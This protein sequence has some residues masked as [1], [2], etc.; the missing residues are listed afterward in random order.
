M[1][2]QN[3]CTLTP[4]GRKKIIQDTLELCSCEFNTLMVCQHP[5]R[6]KL[7]CSSLNC[8]KSEHEFDPSQVF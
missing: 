1:K 5:N 3:P 6:V 4:E 2:K 7:K 8:P